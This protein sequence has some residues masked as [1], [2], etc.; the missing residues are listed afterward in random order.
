ML[1]K[2]L[3]IT[4]FL[5]MTSC[6]YEAM[7][8]LENS[9]KYDFSI[10]G[11]TFEGDRDI[12]AMIKRKFNGYTKI[13]KERRFQLNIKSITNKVILVKNAAGEATN[14]ENNTTT[15]TEVFLDGK[16][17]AVV[18]ISKALKY[19]NIAN[20]FD[21][22]NYEKELKINLAETIADELIFKLSNIK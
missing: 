13:E 14:F 6:G 5:L 7:Y 17:I 16:L 22:Q 15:S 8:S 19:D 11:I 20:K 4:I 10:T 21:L 12:N 3:S 9:V 1:K 2:I 18:Q